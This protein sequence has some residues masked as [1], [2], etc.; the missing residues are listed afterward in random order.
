M[1]VS[2]QFHSYDHTAVLSHKIS[3]STFISLF[4]DY[5]RFFIELGVSHCWKGGRGRGEGK[6]DSGGGGNT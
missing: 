4:A 3:V 1:H 5:A 2:S 6:E